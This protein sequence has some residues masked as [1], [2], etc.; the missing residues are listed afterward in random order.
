ML[1]GNCNWKKTKARGSKKEIC[2]SGLNSGYPE[3]ISWIENKKFVKY[4]IYGLCLSQQRPMV[5]P[6]IILGF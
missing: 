3:Y 6:A 2:Y 4:Q 5:L 1:S